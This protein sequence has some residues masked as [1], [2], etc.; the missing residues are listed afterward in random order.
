M[1][2]IGLPQ[3]AALEWEKNILQRK[4]EVRDKPTHKDI[5]L[6]QNK[7]PIAHRWGPF[8]LGKILVIDLW[9]I[10]YFL[11]CT[12]RPRRAAAKAW[13]LLLSKTPMICPP[14]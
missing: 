2:I 3:R 13:C 12:A 14:S 10:I 4:K 6:Q 9:T 5:D 8:A 7:I 1:L 11:L